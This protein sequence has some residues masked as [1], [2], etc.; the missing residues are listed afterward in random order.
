MSEGSS[1]DPGIGPRG[2]STAEA[3][4][5]KPEHFIEPASLSFHSE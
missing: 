3:G 1:R 2:V 4:E 5:E